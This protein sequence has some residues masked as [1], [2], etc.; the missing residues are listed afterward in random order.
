MSHPT[1]SIPA[2]WQWASLPALPCAGWEE[3]FPRRAAHGSAWGIGNILLGRWGPLRRAQCYFSTDSENTSHGPAVPARSTG[4]ERGLQPVSAL[5]CP[6]GLFWPSNWS[7]GHQGSVLQSRETGL[8]L[9]GSPW[10]LSLMTL[11][12]PTR[13]IFFYLLQGKSHIAVNTP[14]FW[15]SSANTSLWLFSCFI[16]CN[17]CL[18]ARSFC[19]LSASCKVCIPFCRKYWGADMQSLVPKS[20]VP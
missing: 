12:L 3:V 4:T 18:L 1:A 7:L 14:D 13:W 2:R 8:S 11:C 19:G 5:L 20:Q 6:H 17:I 10:K 9:G 16:Y 15:G